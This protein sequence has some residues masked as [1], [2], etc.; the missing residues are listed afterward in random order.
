MNTCCLFVS[1]AA[2]RCQEITAWC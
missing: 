2:G 1:G